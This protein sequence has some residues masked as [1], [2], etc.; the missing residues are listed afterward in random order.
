MEKDILTRVENCKDQYGA[1]LPTEELPCGCT[2]AAGR[3]PKKI[4]YGASVKIVYMC[5]KHKK[6]W[7]QEMEKG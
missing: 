4:L 6:Y 1:P 7:V 2:Y 5:F 3:V